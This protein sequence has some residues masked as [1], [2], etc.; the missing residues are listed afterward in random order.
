MV[1]DLMSQTGY[2]RIAAEEAFAPPE[3]L[4]R[5]RKVKVTDDRPIGDADKKKLYQ[6]NAER[7]FALAS[8]EEKA[9]T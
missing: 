6:S 5:Y 4:D 9:G 8:I 3:I 2:L 7:V 1:A